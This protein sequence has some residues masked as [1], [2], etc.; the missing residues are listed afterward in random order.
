MEKGQKAIG[1]LT[2]CE[3]KVCYQVPKNFFIHK[4]CAG[5]L[6]NTL[7]ELTREYQVML[8]IME[9]FGKRW[10]LSMGR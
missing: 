6:G 10:K 2:N 9:Q 8:M 5:N 7:D 1:V 4:D 3:Q